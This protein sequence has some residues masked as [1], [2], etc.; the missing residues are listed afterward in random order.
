MLPK[1]SPEEKDMRTE[2]MNTHASPKQIGGTDTGQVGLSR[3][4]F[5]KATGAV[6]GGLILGFFVPGAG[7]LALAQPDKPMS[8]PNAFLRIAPDNTVTVSINRLEFGQ[9]VQ[10]SLPMLIAEELDADWAAMQSALAPAG[11]A[12]NDP[13]F[14]MQMTGGSNSVKNSFIQYREIGA[15]ARLMLVAAA[16]QQWNV[17]ADQ[18]RTDKGVVYGPGG[19]QASYGQLAE[20]AMKQPVPEKVALKSP[21]EFRIIGKP[22]PRL[23]ALA[24]SSG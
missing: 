19:R 22:M 2:W 4:G 3:R 9:G 21:S 12:Y 17:S 5:L 11:S 20:A 24:K 7:R 13:A 10:T 15:R 6:S 18:C 8:A 23:D 14:G 1:R 16:A